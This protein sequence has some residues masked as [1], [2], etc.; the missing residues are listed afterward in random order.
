MAVHSEDP[1]NKRRARY[2]ASIDDL[3]RI[4]PVAPTARRPELRPLFYERRNSLQ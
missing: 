2:I 1:A 4:V 3:I